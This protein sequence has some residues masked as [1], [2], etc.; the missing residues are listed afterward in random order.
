MFVKCFEDEK[1]Y[2]NL[3]YYFITLDL[4]P[5]HRILIQCSSKQVKSKDLKVALDIIAFRDLSS[6]LAT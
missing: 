1:Y 5:S 2:I 4:C 6:P 3:K